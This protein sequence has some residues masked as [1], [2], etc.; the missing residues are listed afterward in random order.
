[1][2]KVSRSVNIP[3]KLLGNSAYEVGDRDRLQRENR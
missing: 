3:S 2:K 1:M